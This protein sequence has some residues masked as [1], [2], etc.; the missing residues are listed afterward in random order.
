MRQIR[1]LKLVKDYDYD[2]KYNSGKAIVIVDALS[3][4]IFISRLI[5]Q[6]QIKTNL[7]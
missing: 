3:R 2:I 7:D 5:V 4:K 6:R 1:W